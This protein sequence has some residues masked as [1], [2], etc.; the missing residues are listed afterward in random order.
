M[1]SG[2]RAGCAAARRCPWRPAPVG[3]PC[4]RSTNRRLRRRPPA[5]RRRWSARRAGQTRRRPGSRAGRLSANSVARPRLAAAAR[6]DERHQPVPIEEL[7]DTGKVRGPADEARQRRAQ[8]GRCRALK[9]RDRALAT[10]RQAPRAPRPGEGSRTPTGAARAR[11]PTQAPRPTH[12]GRLRNARSASAW[13]PD[14]YNANISCPRSRSRKGIAAIAASRSGTKSASRPTANNASNRSSTVTARN[15]SRRAAAATAV[16]TSANSPS[17]SPR[18]RPSASSKHSSAEPVRASAGAA[19]PSRTSRSKHNASTS[20][21][22][23]HQDIP[24]RTRLD[25]LRAQRS[26]RLGHHQ[27]QRVPRLPW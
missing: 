17:A 23:K 16:G 13:R 18:Q 8:V 21:G 2:R 26:A 10:G 20:S 5:R 19:R 7:A 14:R 15:S 9:R 12:G 22:G 1:R 24:W 3:P 6:S 25:R 27:L 4:R 11:A